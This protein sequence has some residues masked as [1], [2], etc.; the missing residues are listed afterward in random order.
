M[1][2]EPLQRPDPCALVVQ[3]RGDAMI[4]S[5]AEVAGVA[6]E[7]DVLVGEQDEQGQ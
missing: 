3:A 2:I 5:V 6:G 1:R 4:H 7:D